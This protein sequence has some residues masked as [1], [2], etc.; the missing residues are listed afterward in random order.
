MIRGIQSQ[1][2]V[3]TVKYLAANNQ[4]IERMT[5]S[6]DID[7]RTLHEI[8]LPA[9]EAAVE[10]GEVGSVMC[11][12]NKV[13]SV[14]GCEHPE[15][16]TDVLKKQFGFAG[17]VMSDWNATHSTAPA[18]NAGLDMEMAAAENG[19]YFGDALKTA[20]LD[21]EVPMSRLDD[22]VRRIAYAMFSVG[23]FDNPAAPSHRDSRPS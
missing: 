7:E 11:S 5:G 2:V 13:N 6:S 23:A 14:Y 17:F 8:Y 9:F 19:K 12:Y 16:L 22:M 18:A 4:E 21:G 1:N 15:L 3:A 10:K 20:V